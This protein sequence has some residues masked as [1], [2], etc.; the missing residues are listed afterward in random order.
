MPP[1]DAVAGG[2]ASKAVREGAGG[3]SGTVRRGPGRDLRPQGAHAR[4]KV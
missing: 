3:R 4:G 2:P 1:A